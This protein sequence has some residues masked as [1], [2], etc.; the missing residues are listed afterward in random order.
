VAV[1]DPDLIDAAALAAAL[2]RR[3]LSAVVC[4]AFGPGRDVGDPDPIV[5][6]TT[7]AY[8]A[9]LTALAEA[10]GAG[11]VAG[12]AYGSVGLARPLD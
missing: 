3:G 1:E 9:R 10:L 2:R 12:P 11:V 4:G 7:L 6:A 8:L 5:R